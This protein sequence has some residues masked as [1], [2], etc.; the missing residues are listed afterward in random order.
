MTDMVQILRAKAAFKVQRGGLMNPSS[1]SDIAMH[2]VGWHDEG[3]PHTRVLKEAHLHLSH[4][5]FQR[6]IRVH[7][8]E[9]T[10]KP[11]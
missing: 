11:L 5:S 1:V 9:F 3:Q 6:S 7:E 8:K 4:P 2:Q 10:T